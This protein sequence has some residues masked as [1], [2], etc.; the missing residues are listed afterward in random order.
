MNPLKIEVAFHTPFFDLLSKT[1]DPGEEPWYSLRIPDYTAI[2]AITPE[3]KILVVRQYRP[4][5]ERYTL[6]LPAG[7]LDQ[8]GEEPETA[9]RRELLEETGFEADEMEPLGA[10]FPD[11]GRMTNRIWSFLAKGVRRVEGQTPE[12]GMEVL[13]YSLPDLTRAILA[14]EFDHSLHVAPLLV[15]M[16]QGKLKLG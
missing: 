16:L 2:L 8:P 6:E 7:L 13:E 9:A 11:T 10:M 3:Q 4:A 1:I 12:P 5:V 15:A 14:G